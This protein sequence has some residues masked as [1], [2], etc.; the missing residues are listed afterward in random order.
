[1]P[2]F[3]MIL[4]ENSRIYVIF[5]E[6]SQK[7]LLHKTWEACAPCPSISYTYDLKTDEGVWGR[8]VTQ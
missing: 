4:P 3:C 1:M 2:E 5:P 8:K 6:N 7:I